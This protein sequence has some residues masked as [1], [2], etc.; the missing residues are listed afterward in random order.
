MSIANFHQELTLCQIYSEYF[1][2]LSLPAILMQ[3]LPYTP[4]DRR[5]HRSAEKCSSSL[6]APELGLSS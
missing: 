6:G 1:G 5:E 4:L 3:V 2:H